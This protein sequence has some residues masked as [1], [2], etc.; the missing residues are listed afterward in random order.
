MRYASISVADLNPQG[1]VLRTVSDDQF[2][3]FYHER[4]GAMQ[5]EAM[6]GRNVS[7]VV[8]R[9]RGVL[10]R[11]G[12]NTSESFVVELEDQTPVRPCLAS[13]LCA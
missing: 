11:C 8:A 2:R 1:P 7:L 5:W 10:E 6:F 12:V 3:A 9:N 4:Y 13:V